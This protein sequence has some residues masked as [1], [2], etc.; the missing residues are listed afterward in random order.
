MGTRRNPRGWWLYGLIGLMACLGTAVC[1][2]DCEAQLFGGR[3]AR[4]AVESRRTNYPGWRAAGESSGKT[5]AVVAEAAAS[6]ATAPERPP[7][8]PGLGAIDR[9]ADPAAPQVEPASQAGRP[10]PEHYY[11]GE[12]RRDPAYN[13]GYPNYPRYFG[14]FHSSHYYDLGIPNGDKGLRG[15]GIY[16]APW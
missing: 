9:P 7:F 13:P 1:P 12:W 2:S 16:W 11:R 10:V 5:P 4:G 14:G 6:E 15:N 3:A 8:E